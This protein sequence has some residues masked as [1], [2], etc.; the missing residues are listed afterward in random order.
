MKKYIILSAAI[1]SIGCG[2]DMAA[3]SKVLEQIN[4]SDELSGP[5][6]TAPLPS[7]SKVGTCLKLDFSGLDWPSAIDPRQQEPFSLALNISGSFE[8]PN[9]WQN[10]TNNFDGQ[11]MSYGLLNQN[12]GQGTLQPLL[13]QMRNRYFSQMENTVPTTQR[14][15]LLNML[16]RWEKHTNIVNAPELFEYG[17]SDLDSDEDIKE[18]IGYDPRELF[19]IQLLK[20]NQ[21]SVNWA[22]E[23]LYVGSS[24]KSNWRTAFRGLAQTPGYRSIQVEAATRLHQSALRLFKMFRLTEV[25]SYLFFFD[26][27]VQNG[28][29]P[30]SDIKFLTSKFAGAKMS[31]TQKLNTILERR[32]IHVKKIYRNDV[33]ARKQSIIRG[34]GTVHGSRRDYA[35]EFCANLTVS[36]PGI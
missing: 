22:V 6:E 2:Q 9:G 10:L 29:L 8:G 14:N 34:T 17:L 1:L 24:F 25:R 16:T 32:L 7:T 36:M 13:I 19:T 23:N 5:T 4:S 33:K 12:F 3:T 18:E 21:E 20:K 31:E 26:I 30:E 27:V 15:S 35:K 11:G 28:G